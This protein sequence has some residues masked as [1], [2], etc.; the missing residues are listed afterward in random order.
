MPGARQRSARR[1]RGTRHALYARRNR[2]ASG[3]GG[4]RRVRGQ[5]GCVLALPVL[6]CGPNRV[7]RSP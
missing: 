2:P 3:L 7:Q 6:F 4:G 1:K 5:L